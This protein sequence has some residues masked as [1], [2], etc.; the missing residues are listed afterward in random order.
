[1][2]VIMPLKRWTWNLLKKRAGRFWRHASLHHGKRVHWKPQLHSRSLDGL[3]H[4]IN[5]VILV[6]AQGSI[7]RIGWKMIVKLIN[8]SACDFLQGLLHCGKRDLRKPQVLTLSLVWLQALLYNSV[9][10]HM[11]SSNHWIG[12]K[13][14]VKSTNRAAGEFSTNLLVPRPKKPAQITPT[15]PCFGLTADESLYLSSGPFPWFKPKNRW[16]EDH[17]I[18]KSRCQWVSANLLA[19]RWKKPAQISPT[20]SCF[21]WTAGSS[22]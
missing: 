9:G 8:Q 12:W 6:C 17:E 20:H 3:H 11:R 19:L 5:C 14:I 16:K 15:H 22:L 1:M 13:I 10:V 21:C 4:L 7:Q 18:D 2:A